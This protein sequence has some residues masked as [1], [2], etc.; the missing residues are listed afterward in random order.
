M[1]GTTWFWFG[2][3]SMAETRSCGRSATIPTTNWFVSWIVYGT[4]WVAIVVVPSTS[5]TS[6]SRPKAGGWTWSTYVLSDWVGRSTTTPIA[7]R[8]LVAAESQLADDRRAH[9]S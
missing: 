3:R 2:N 9:R 8:A 6:S 7:R 1:T 4:F 5:A